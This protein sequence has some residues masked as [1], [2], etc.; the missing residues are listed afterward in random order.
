[1]QKVVA[2]LAKLKIALIEGSETV[3]PT[4]LTG[5][6]DIGAG[7]DTA[8]IINGKTGSAPTIT[9]TN[10]PKN[11]STTNKAYWIAASALD[12]SNADITNK[13]SGSYDF[14]GADSNYY[15]VSDSNGGVDRLSNTGDPFDGETG[16]AV[17][18]IQVA[19]DATA[20]SGIIY[21]V[22]S[23]D[24]LGLSLKLQDAT[25][26]KVDSS[27]TVTDGSDMSGSITAQ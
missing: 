17:G 27:L 15:S 19:Q 12:S 1:P 6:L 21:V 20:N 18:S 24:T 2:D 3:A 13:T 7:A 14:V 25:G 5:A 8:V 11:S 16:A 26:A 4:T 9:F 10:V 23:L 22:S